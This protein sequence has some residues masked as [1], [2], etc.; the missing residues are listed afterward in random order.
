MLNYIDCITISL[1]TNTNFLSIWQPI[2]VKSDDYV[3]QHDLSMLRTAFLLKQ[4]HMFKCTDLFTVSNL[5]ISLV[6]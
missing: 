1:Q 2:S 3:I 4:D 5:L 6:T